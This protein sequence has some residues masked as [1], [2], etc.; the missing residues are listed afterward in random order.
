MKK[1]ILILTTLVMAVT[2]NAQ[3]AT[4]ESLREAEL[5]RF[6]VMIAQDEKG[7]EKIILKINLNI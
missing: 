5:N 6:K 2:A 4:I 7:L 3:K 1:I